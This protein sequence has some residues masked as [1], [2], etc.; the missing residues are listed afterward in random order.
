MAREI[1]NKDFQLS[2]NLPNG[3]LK[4][5]Q[6]VTLL[7]LVSD[8]AEIEG[9]S[10][11]SKNNLSIPS[12]MLRP[13][14][15][16]DP[17]FT[18]TEE[19]QYIE[20]AQKDIFMDGRA[21]RTSGGAENIPNT[22]LAIRVGKTDQPIMSGV[23]ELRLAGNLTPNEVKN[24]RDSEANKVTGTLDAGTDI[25]NT[26]R[27]AIV[28]LNWASL[29]QI[30]P[31][32]GS[33]TALGVNFPP[34]AGPNDILIRIRLRGAAGGV[35]A[36]KQYKMNG[37]SNGPFSKDY[38]IEIPESIYRTASARSL[39]YPITVE[40]L[41]EDLE[42]RSDS[43]I[44]KNPFNPEG[45]N[46]LEEGQKRFTTFSFARLQGM[47]P[48]ENTNFSETAYIGLRYSAEQFPNI[49]QRKYFIRGI[50]VRIPTGVTI[51]TADTGRI[52][53]PSGYVF[54][55]ITGTRNQ[56]ADKFW[57][58]DP[59]WIL[60]AL[61]TEDYG[62]N[63]DDSKIDKASFY[64]ASLYCSAFGNS[65]KPRYSFNGVIKTRKK[66]LEIIREV[67]ALMRA[68]LYYKNGSL[69]IAL[70][71][72]ENVVSYLFT[73]ANVV[74]GIFNYSGT[75][76]DKKF[77]QV[78][79]SYFNNDIQELDQ[80]SIRE[81]TSF[82]KFGLN[83]INTQALYTTDRDQALRFG[84]SIIYSS[85]FEAEIVSF[86]CGLEAACLL[87][88]FMVI[89]VADRTRE[90]IRAS[91]RINSVTSSTVVVVDDSTDTSVG[92]AGDSFL[93]I[94]KNGGVQE[95]TIQTVSAST[96]TLSSALDPLPQAGTIWAVKTG[97]VQHRKYR[98]TNIK[99]KNNFVFSITA[100][101]YDDNKYTY[102]DNFAASIFGIGREPTT[103]LDK[104]PSPAIQELKEELVVVNNRAQ[105][106]IVLNF[107]HVD[108]AR[109]YQISYKHN[110]GDPV[111]QNTSDNQFIIANNQT[112]IYEFSI[113]TLNSTI[114]LSESVSTRTINAVGLSEPPANVSNLRF[115]E[116][117]D[118][119]ILIW[120]R[121]TDKDV[122]FGG[123][124]KIKYA[125][126]SDGTATPQNANLLLELDGNSDQTII[127]DYQSGEYFVSFID[128]VGNE[129]VGATSVVVNRTITSENLVA[130]Q[131]RENPTFGGLKL[132]LKVDSNGLVLT[133][134]TTIDSITNF[135]TL[136]ID[137]TTSFNNIDAVISGVSSSGEYT[138]QN[139]IDLSAKFKLH[140]EPHFKKRGFN[141]ATEWDSYTDNMDTWPDIFTTSAVVFDKSPELTFQ[142]AKSTTNTPST[143]F[144]TFTKTDIEA[145]TLSFKVLV[146]N[147]SSYE[148]IDI[149]EL[150]VNLL[151]RPRTER[152]ID[153]YSDTNG[154]LTSS[155]SGATTVIFNKKFFLGTTDVGGG[156]EK[157]KPVIAI[158]INNM[159]SGDFFTIDSVSSSDFVVSI[160]NNANQTN[161]NPNG[162]VERQFTY[163][164]FG[165]GEG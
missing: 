120:D 102:I 69:K 153:K 113:R 164:A 144:Q 21:I 39:N 100:V 78:N 75:E 147:D 37:I 23:N 107:A 52:I 160:K 6:F 51:D 128:V 1:S 108:G 54:A 165:Y 43:A 130:A 12:S 109:N 73:N 98:I 119:L 122:L 57:T 62:L 26:P 104:L 63:I 114:L 74:D 8:G 76:K 38:R 157:F 117:K 34:F 131:I 112:G 36:D 137:N 3:F 127:K 136:A 135:D 106:R 103:L 121:A 13:A 101:V 59:A 151:F 60:Y 152:S 18:S 140:I 20:L 55:A 163:S 94:D 17:E 116:S 162:F 96:V 143:D 93:I 67:A 14:S 33:S 155:G 24:N 66:A 105:S 154:I 88:P 77:T 64:A 44:G 110:S 56:S 126:V 71:K 118:D 80:V 46:I 85:T 142:V 42:F 68:T 145:Q 141:T 58:S 41:R 86:D 15:A 70:D 7:D 40:V 124:V 83:Q 48:S 45:E 159:Q 72:P 25:N 10:T 9:F 91:G 2:E 53:Y 19:R 5:Q 139:N 84:R 4:A 27:A 61:L 49:P 81:E 32:D 156:T 16:T 35:L 161:T 158:N 65:G 115:E 150:G 22:S 111:V 134:G 82:Q 99:Q 30:S 129:S 148:N 79:V 50:K 138:F 31:D 149:E 90:L 92:I 28:T 97:N 89:K 87:E 123:K 132:N 11:P 95:K 47:I 29:R 133:S 125:L 146:N